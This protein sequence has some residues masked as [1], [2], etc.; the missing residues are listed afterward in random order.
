V[1]LWAPSSSSRSKMPA[2]APRG[3]A[4]GAQVLTVSVLDGRQF[5]TDY[6]LRLYVLG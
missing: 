3:G 2:S 6:I 1:Q 4:D 5:L